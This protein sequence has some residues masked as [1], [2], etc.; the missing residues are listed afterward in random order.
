MSPDH[1]IQVYREGG[2]WW[3][4]VIPPA[5]GW[6]DEAYP[7]ESEALVHARARRFA[8]G[9]QIKGHPRREKRKAVSRGKT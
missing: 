2:Q 6:P 4:A 9:W 5:T 1:E 3:V 8:T 7:T